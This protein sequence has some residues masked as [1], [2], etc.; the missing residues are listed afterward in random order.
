MSTWISKTIRAVLIISVTFSILWTTD[1]SLAQQ[2]SVLL[3]QGQSKNSNA[4]VNVP[5]H[6]ICF[7]V[8]VSVSYSGGPVQLS[9]QS[10]SAAPIAIDDEVK[11][12]VTHPGGSQATF[13]KASQTHDI[14]PF[15]F[16]S[17]LAQGTN[18]V[19]VQ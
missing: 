18:S 2:S 16:S 7:D 4:G 14:G 15:D 6:Q 13:D 5:N 1:Y 11:I 9:S 17:Y 19:E 12:I 8:T 3:W 10:G